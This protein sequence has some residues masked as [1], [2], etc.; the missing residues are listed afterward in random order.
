[1]R[2]RK[3]NHSKR[4]ICLATACFM[5]LSLVFVTE[6]VPASAAS[7]HA[8]SAGKMSAAGSDGRDTVESVLTG[9]DEDRE[10]YPGELLAWAQEKANWLEERYQSSIE[11]VDRL[12]EEQQAQTY[13]RAALM[14]ELLAGYDLLGNIPED[15]SWLVRVNQETNTVTVYRTFPVP[16]EEIPFGEGYT[17][18]IEDAMTEAREAAEREKA[19]REAAAKE[20]EAA[21]DEEAQSENDSEDHMLMEFEH[22]VL[23]Q[24]RKT[25]APEQENAQTVMLTLPVYSCP[26]S[27]GSEGRTPTGT[28]TVYD[29]LRWHELVGPT[30]GQ[31]CCH[32]APSYLFHSMPYDRP[33]DPNSLETDAYN[34]LGTAASHGCVRLAAVDAKYIYDHIPSGTKV[35]I[36][37][38]TK[39]D[40]PLGVPERPYVGEWDKGY[41]PTDPEYRPE[42]SS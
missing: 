8:E 26:C 28:F 34:L 15:A 35:E 24:L 19:A 11:E 6:P 23:R 18:I 32:F 1:M 30:W 39:A 21:Q 33:N 16:R 25:D 17:N 12:R 3:Q 27:V 37:V 41:D 5:V 13:V 29:H 40:D 31:W 14:K 7:A 4:I 38:G 10:A 36:F 42:E 9:S 20:A 2:I 22:V